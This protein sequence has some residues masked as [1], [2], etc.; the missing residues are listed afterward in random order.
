MIP[1]FAESRMQSN[2][3][4]LIYWSVGR[5]SWLIFPC[6]VASIPKMQSL[7]FVNR[8]LCVDV[9]PMESIPN[10]YRDVDLGDRTFQPTNSQRMDKELVTSSWNISD[11]LGN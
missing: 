5:F 4:L 2:L 1:D 11:N 10:L 8:M 7:R 3:P 9:A 6:Q